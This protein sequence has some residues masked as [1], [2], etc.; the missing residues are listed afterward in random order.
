[1]PS[2]ARTAVFGSVLLV[3]PACMLA[4]CWPLAPS[5]GTIEDA[6]IST[7]TG[8]VLDGSAGGAGDGDV[9]SDALASE[10]GDAEAGGGDGAV[11][12]VP[13]PSVTIAAGKGFGCRIDGSGNVWCWGSSQFGQT[14][15]FGD[16]G[17][18]SPSQ[19]VSGI[20]GATALALGDYHACAVTSKNQVYCWGL[21]NADQLGH[22]PG[23]TGTND[24]FCAGSGHSVPCNATPTLVSVGAAAGVSAAG[25]FT[26]SVGTDG[27][28]SCWGAVQTTIPEDAGTASCGL[29]T[30]STGGTCYSAPF[31]VPGVSGVTQLS[32]ASE[33]A[34]ALVAEGGVSCWGANDEAQSYG[35]ICQGSGDCT[36]TLQSLAQAESVA[37][38]T[39]F[40]CALL[41]EAGTADCVGDNSYGELGHAPGAMGDQQ[42]QGSTQSY[43]TS[44]EPVVGLGAVSE[45]VASG[46][47]AA[48]ALVAG[49]AVECWGN[50]ATSPSA[51][52]VVT[53]TGLPAMTAL[54]VPDTSYACGVSGD[55][56]VWCWDLSSDAGPA[57]VQ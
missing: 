4:S 50:V 13:Y 55:A 26:C 23:A 32:V 20:S 45:L 44:Y 11:V 6:A 37:V 41:A 29:G 51:G 35:G 25:A 40:S 14:G 54:G 39:S 43:N 30:A 49:G 36:P 28:V 31:V 9:S 38:G 17:V 33:H 34:C 10:G 47:Q 22:L 3:G 48:C 57:Q 18:T 46:S 1:M 8:S 7:H 19:Q 21:N 56:S 27:T 52:A 5:G 16:G 24:G 15:T 42:P 2:F 12:I 53:I